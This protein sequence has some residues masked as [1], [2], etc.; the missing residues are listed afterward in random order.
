MR[1]ILPL[2]VFGLLLSLPAF[3]Q[4][5]YPWS[6]YGGGYGGYYQNAFGLGVSA[7]RTFV[8]PPYF[9]LY[10]PVYYSHEIVRRPMGMGPFAYT[11]WGG[12]FAAPVAASAPAAPVAAAPTPEPLWVHNP[13]VKG[14]APAKEASADVLPEPV[15]N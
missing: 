7:P 5:Y 8:S 9:S 10:P 13:F 11:G 14:K 4:A 12:N 15:Q 1:R 3:A 2:L 6:G